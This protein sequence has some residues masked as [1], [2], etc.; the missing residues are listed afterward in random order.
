MSR[1]RKC[2]EKTKSK[3]PTRTKAGSLQSLTRKGLALKSLVTAMG[4]AQ[5]RTITGTC[6]GIH[7]DRYT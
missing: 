3:C 2:S 7:M 6:H 1:K 5:R 4:E